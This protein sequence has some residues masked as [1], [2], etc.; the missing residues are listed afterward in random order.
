MFFYFYTLSHTVTQNESTWRSSASRLLC[1]H[2]RAQSWSR[3]LLAN[4]PAP[5]WR[6]A[7]ASVCKHSMADSV[8][9]EH[10]RHRNKKKVDA[11]CSL[12][13]MPRRAVSL[14]SGDR[15]ASLVMFRTA[16]SVCV[17]CT[18]RCCPPLRLPKA[19]RALHTS[20]DSCWHP[21]VH[22]WSCS[23]LAGLRPSKECVHAAVRE[24]DYYFPSPPPSSRIPPRKSAV[25]VLHF[26]F[27]VHPQLNTTSPH[28]AGCCQ[29]W[30]YAPLSSCSTC[31]SLA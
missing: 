5:Y 16:A 21:R 30:R 1:W 8:S 6:S 23:L 29:T 9:T 22:A 19:A 15:T 10:D 3:S 4:G 11:A 26:Y 27:P 18:V 31:S 25:N 24:R 7:T 13:P 17:A 28:P 14:A 20:S 2:P 12:M